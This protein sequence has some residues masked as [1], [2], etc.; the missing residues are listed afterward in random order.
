MSPEFYQGPLEKLFS[1]D[2]KFIDVR[3]PIEF[4]QG[5]FPNAINLPLLSD[6]QRHLIGIC[7]KELGQVEAIALGHKLVS[8]EDRNEKMKAWLS[9]INRGPSETYLYCFRGG[10][11]SQISQ[12]WIRELGGKILIIEGGYKEST[13]SAGDIVSKKML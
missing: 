12:Q 6:E 11:R 8:G 5:A 9:E 3:A 13:H 2:I 4:R 1:D 10:L 7:Y